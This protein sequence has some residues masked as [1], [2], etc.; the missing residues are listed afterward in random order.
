M[1]R[2]FFKSFSF[3]LQVLKNELRM[4][5]KTSTVAIVLLQT[6]FRAL[7]NY[8]FGAFRVYIIGKCI[9]NAS[10]QCINESSLDFLMFL[11]K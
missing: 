6:S 2:S 4:G 8:P 5:V 3:F 1:R 9:P 11:N 10:V 7:P